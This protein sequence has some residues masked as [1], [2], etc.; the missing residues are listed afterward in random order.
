M[1]KKLTQIPQQPVTN[2]TIK[3]SPFDTFKSKRFLRRLV[4]K[5]KKS[6]DEIDLTE[7]QIQ[8]GTNDCLG[9]QIE[10]EFSQLG[11]TGQK[12]FFIT[13]IFLPFGCYFQRLFNSNLEGKPAKLFSK[14]LDL[15]HTSIIFLWWRSVHKKLVS[16]QMI[17]FAAINNLSCSELFKLSK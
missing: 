5:I 14:I 11:Q 16:S 3:F 2:K 4:R 6:L 9:D 1:C 17:V 8:F 12:W 15:D 13:I 10:S 7:D